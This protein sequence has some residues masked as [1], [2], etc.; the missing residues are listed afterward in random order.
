MLLLHTVADANTAR[1][2][3]HLKSKL[4]RKQAPQNEIWGLVFLDPQK[5]GALGE[6]PFG[7]LADY[8]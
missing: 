2:A 4:R 6:L 8:E 3:E 5:S 1:D 7:L